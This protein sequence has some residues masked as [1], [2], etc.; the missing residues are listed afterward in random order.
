MRWM[1]V[2]ALGSLVAATASQ[3]HL[4]ETGS[5]L[6]FPV[7]AKW[8]QVYHS[9]NPKIDVATEAT[10]SGAGITG[11]TNGT[12]D[13]GAS[14]AYLTDEQRAAAGLMNIAVTISAQTVDYN[15][16]EV[17]D[18]HLQLTPS[19]LARIYDGT[20]KYWDDAQIVA[21]NK[22]VAKKLP[23]VAI[24]PIVRSDSAGDTFLFTQY[25]DA[26]AAWK[27]SVGFGTTVKWP[28]L[29]LEQSANGNGGVLKLCGDTKYSICY[30]GISFLL[31]SMGTSLHY[32]AL[33]N[34]A[35]NFVMPSEGG[36]GAAAVTMVDKTPDSESV[37]L[38]NTAAP[39]AY[40]IVNYEYAIVKAKQS[41][42]VK[43]KAMRD[44][45]T[46][47]IDNKGGN[48]G[49]NLSPGFTQLP[50]TVAKLSRI[51]IAKIQ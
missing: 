14:D 49:P 1:I 20:V 21:V 10:G 15:V 5:S 7:I 3:V 2:L 33:Q 13:I 46:W 47:A 35:G 37:S 48:N 36:I 6:L 18:A 22:N 11:A 41:D 25:L 44:F 4:K 50:P 43:A 34:P 28:A 27:S 38:V 17:S 30:L 39:D 26:D 19:L 40:P 24:V 16:P 42:P 8:A 9:S 32:G 51:Q 23:H 45:F 31:Q 29:A 12:A